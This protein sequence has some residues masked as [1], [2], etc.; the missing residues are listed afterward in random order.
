MIKRDNRA[1][2]IW[3]MFIRLIT[4]NKGMLLSPINTLTHKSAHIR[5]NIEISN[6]N[7]YL[8]IATNNISTYFELENHRGKI[9]IK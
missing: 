3:I 2:K 8:R 4:N 9:K 1:N 5:S 7:R 6:N